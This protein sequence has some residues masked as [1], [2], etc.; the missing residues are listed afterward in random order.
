VSEG[1]R[2]RVVGV[3]RIE[4][5]EIVFD[6]RLDG[7]DEKTELVRA[8]TRVPGVIL[9]P[10]FGLAEETISSARG[11]V[12][13]WTHERRH[14][15]ESLY[16][17]LAVERRAPAVRSE[18]GRQQPD[19]VCT[20]CGGIGE[21]KRVAAGADGQP[22]W[23][24][25]PKTESTPATRKATPVPC[26]ACRRADYEGHVEKDISATGLAGELERLGAVVSGRTATIR[27]RLKGK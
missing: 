5:G 1:P 21:V 9:V 2:A 7:A 13:R 26:P 27:E 25:L 8:T 17:R 16:E 10:F 22:S 12:M 19:A 24:F 6:V 15:M 20:L 23:A 4:Q 3:P 11:E 18:V 14:F